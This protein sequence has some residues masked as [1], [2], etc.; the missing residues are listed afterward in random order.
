MEKKNAAAMPLQPT[1]NAFP[2]IMGIFEEGYGPELVQTL[3][4]AIQKYVRALGADGDCMGK[5]DSENLFNLVWFLKAVLKDC[6]GV[7]VK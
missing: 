5:D 2:T 1:V 4:D 7:D 6:C 3:T